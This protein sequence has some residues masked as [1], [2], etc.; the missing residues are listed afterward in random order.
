MRAMIMTFGPTQ[1]VKSLLELWGV[2]FDGMCNDDCD[3]TAGD[4]GTLSHVDKQFKALPFTSCFEKLNEGVKWVRWGSHHWA[5]KAF[6]PKRHRKLL[7]L[8]V[9]VVHAGQKLSDATL[10]LL[11]LA[12]PGGGGAQALLC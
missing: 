4:Y 6:L 3:D 1:E 2:L 10:M 12:A 7:V 9:Q 8:C 11:G 5:I